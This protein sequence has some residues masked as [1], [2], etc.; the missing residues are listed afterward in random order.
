M[1]DNRLPKQVLYGELSSGERKIEGQKKSYIDQIKSAGGE[2]SWGDGVSVGSHESSGS[3]SK[4]GSSESK[5][6]TWSGLRL[7]SSVVSCVE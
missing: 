6:A 5:A 7:W 1:Y 3:P 4:V 2:I